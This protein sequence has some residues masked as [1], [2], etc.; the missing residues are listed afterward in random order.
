ML[1]SLRDVRKSDVVKEGGVDVLGVVRKKVS[2]ED[3][4]RGA[5][6]F[7]PNLG[8]VVRSYLGS[9]RVGT[10]FRA[11]GGGFERTDACLGGGSFLSQSL[12]GIDSRPRGRFDDRHEVLCGIEKPIV[13]KR[14]ISPQNKRRERG[15]KKEERGYLRDILRGSVDVSEEGDVLGERERSR[16]R[17]DLV[18]SCDLGG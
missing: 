5:V 18:F 1:D 13:K 15:G 9:V 12:D 17:R 7:G 4:R 8:P 6:T 10:N 3:L 16:V 2:T 11:I 14:K